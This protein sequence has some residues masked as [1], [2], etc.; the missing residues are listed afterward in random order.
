MQFTMKAGGVPVGH[1]QAEFTG[2][3]PFEENVERYGEA[4]L[5]KW[6]VLSGEHQ[7]AEASRICS[8]KFSP[9]SALAQ[10]AIALKGA[11]IEPGEHFS[12]ESVIGGRGTVIVEQTESGNTRVGAFLRQ[13]F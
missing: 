3:E 11:P 6:R 1:Y 9:K 5:L 13:T 7:G 4:V 8:K 2:I 12:F 10:F